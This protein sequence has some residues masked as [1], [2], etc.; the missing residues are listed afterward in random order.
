M[1]FNTPHIFNIFRDLMINVITKGGEISPSPFVNLR[2]D[3][4]H[5]KPVGL[6]QWTQYAF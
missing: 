3:N 2:I 1:P 6:Q 4:T 5:Y